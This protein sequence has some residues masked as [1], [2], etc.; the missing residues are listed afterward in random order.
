MFT[1]LGDIGV[2]IYIY[3]CV[4]VISLYMIYIYIHMHAC[5]YVFFIV[6][7]HLFGICLCVCVWW[8]HI[9]SF[10]ACPTLNAYYHITLHLP[11]WRFNQISNSPRW[12]WLLCALAFLERMPGNWPMLW[13]LPPVFQSDFYILMGS[14]NCWLVVWNHGILNRFHR[15]WKCHTANWLSLHD[16]SEGLVGTTNQKWCILRLRRVF[17]GDSDDQPKD[18]GIGCFPP[19]FRKQPCRSSG[20]LLQFVIEHGPLIELIYLLQM[21]MFHGFWYVYQR[22]FD[23]CYGRPTS[24]SSWHRPNDFPQSLCSSHHVFPSH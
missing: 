24:A 18:L 6:Y 10:V 12:Q 14:W 5:M 3:V 23:G 9:L 15:V 11:R 2:Y 7:I 4:C 1:A 22:V 20:N 13:H 19:R 16:F 17:V 21:V 8:N